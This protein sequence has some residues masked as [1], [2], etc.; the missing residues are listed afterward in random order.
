LP[1]AF[2]LLQDVQADHSG[3]QILVG[4]LASV[5]VK[6]AAALADVLLA[7]F[8]TLARILSAGPDAQRR[9]LGDMPAAVACLS[10]VREAMLHALITDV[11]HTPVLSS[12]KAVLS[13]LH[14]ALAHEPREQVRALFLNHRL[15]LIRDEVLGHGCVAR[16]VV[17]PREIM[18]RALELGATGLVLAHN[19][20][21]GDLQPS[22][23]DIQIT[24][25]LVEAG[26]ALDVTINDHIIISRYGHT[27]LR[28]CGLI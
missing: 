1:Q 22:R 7:E 19:H 25:Q 3:R 11:A 21:S 10:L 26:R 27:S 9:V 17:Y 15:N 5:Q 14:V 18:R 8:G 24:R 6:E 2:A 23:D 28:S 4:L 16:A 20:P 13:Y 12:A